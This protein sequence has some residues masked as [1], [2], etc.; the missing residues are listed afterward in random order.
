M[1]Q[2]SQ[3]HKT[4]KILF[5]FVVCSTGKKLWQ[6]LTVNA[7][8]LIFTGI[9]FKSENFPLN[10]MTL[11]LFFCYVF[12]WNYKLSLVNIYEKVFGRGPLSIGLDVTRLVVEIQVI[13]P[14]VFSFT[15]EVCHPVWII[16]KTQ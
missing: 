10:V 12:L 3:M 5:C 16:Y 14:Y 11:Q 1:N 15:E 4:Y 9:I 2:H 13:F 6:F 8:T 7:I